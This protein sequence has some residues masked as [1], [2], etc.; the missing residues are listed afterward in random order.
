MEFTPDMK[1]H[2]WN[3]I[4]PT[5]PKGRILEENTL[6]KVKS[7]G[8][9]NRWYPLEREVEERYRGS[10][11]QHKETLRFKY[12]ESPHQKKKKKGKCQEMN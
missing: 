5:V 1:N 8:E 10:N 3:E 6:S 4:R 11:L 12:K 9:E 2:H 7:R